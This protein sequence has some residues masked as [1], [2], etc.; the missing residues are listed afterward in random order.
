M[1]TRSV[2]ASLRSF[3]SPSLTL[4]PVLSVSSGLWCYL[5]LQHPSTPSLR[6][7]LNPSV[8]PLS[9]LPPCPM[10][11]LP[12]RPDSSD[13]DAAPAE[14][15]LQGSF[16]DLRVEGRRK[17][18]RS[19]PASVPRLPRDGQLW[20]DV[21]CVSAR[22]THRLNAGVLFPMDIKKALFPWSV[23]D[24]F[25]FHISSDE[26]KEKMGRSGC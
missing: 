21:L 26:R 18:R 5:F 19:K 1:H 14:P 23:S 24:D 9:F 2:A 10:T 3:A 16:K 13:T 4:R 7:R 11:L 25:T 22:F 8:A 20:T 6:L 12:A 17:C 15:H